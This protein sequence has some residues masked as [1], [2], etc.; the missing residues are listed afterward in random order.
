MPSL[1]RPAV[2]LTGPLLALL[3][4]CTSLQDDKRADALLASTN[5][6]RE[7]LRW[8][9]WDTAMD[10]LHADARKDVDTQALKNVRVTGL[11]VVRPANITPENTALRVVRIE[12]VLEDEQ[13][14]K[15]LTDKQDWRWDDAT[16][17]WRLHSGLPAF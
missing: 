4:A 7:A 12:Y 13:R 16:R 14:V 8:G 15:E 2:L 5:N 10:Y 1:P 3:C 9:Y 17:A 6:Y 11:E